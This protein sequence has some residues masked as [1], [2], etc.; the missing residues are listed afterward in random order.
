[1]N[2]LWKTPDE[3]PIAYCKVVMEF[4]RPYGDQIPEDEQDPVYEC[5]EMRYYGD[6][7]GCEWEYL[8]QCSRWCYLEDLVK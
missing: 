3:K 4:K 5:Y 8:K 7:D 2:S 1:M 6:G